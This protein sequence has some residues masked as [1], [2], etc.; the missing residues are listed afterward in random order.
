MDTPEQLNL[1]RLK[2]DAQRLLE[3]SRRLAE[4][5]AQLGVR[6]VA[7]TAHLAELEQRTLAAMDK[8]Q[9]LQRRL[10]ERASE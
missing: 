7:L 8:A 4:R 9:R 5:S 1:D 6:T 3:R 2:E 10:P